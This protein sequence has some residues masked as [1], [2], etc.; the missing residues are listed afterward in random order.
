[1]KRIVV[2]SGASLR[3]SHNS[4]RLQQDESLTNAELL[5]KIVLQ[6]RN[7]FL[8]LLSSGV[9]FTDRHS[10]WFAVD[11]LAWTRYVA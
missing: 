11:C 2:C 8:C 7:L 1:M 9:T 10:W 3:R 6:D 5:G 4:I